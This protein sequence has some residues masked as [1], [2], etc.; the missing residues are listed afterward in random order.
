MIPGNYNEFEGPV[1]T[2]LDKH[3]PYKK[4][5]IRGSNK[6]HVSK[7]MRGEV[8]CKTR[9]KKIANKTNEE[10]TCRYKRQRNKIVKL[11]KVAMKRYFRSLDP[12]TIRMIFS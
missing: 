11:N 1:G 5:T 9:F 7:E 10:D 6:P 4:A 8:M 3:A 2:S 12:A